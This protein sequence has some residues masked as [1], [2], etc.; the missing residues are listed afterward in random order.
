MVNDK[1]QDGSS[2]KEI[3]SFLI[4]KYGEW[5]VYNPPLNKVNLVLWMLPYVI[6]IV[7][8]IMI[9][10]MLKNRRY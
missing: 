1:I 4:E 3:Y 7:G 9:I 2:E 6:F 5:I 8:G 10:M